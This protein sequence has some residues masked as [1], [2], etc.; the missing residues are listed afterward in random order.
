MKFGHSENYDGCHAAQLGTE[1]KPDSE[2]CRERMRQAMMNDDMA[3]RDCRRL[4]SVV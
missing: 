3:S 1:A 4:S 2:G